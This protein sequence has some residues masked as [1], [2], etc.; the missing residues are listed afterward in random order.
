MKLEELPDNLK[1]DYDDDSLV[2]INDRTLNYNSKV[3]P[4]LIKDIKNKTLQVFS[5]TYMH[6]KGDKSPRIYLNGRGKESGKFKMKVQGFKPY[7]YV[8][9]DDGSYTTYLGRKCEKY[10][11]ETHPSRVKYFR[12]RKRKQGYPMP[13]EADILFVRRFL[14][15]MY[16]YFKSE[17]PI[18][19]RIAIIDIETNYP[20]N[21]D[22]IAWS[23][24]DMEGPIIYESKYE[25][26]DPYILT[27][28]L[29]EELLNY[30]VVTGWSVDFDIGCI[31]DTLGENYNLADDLAVVDL[32]KITRK[33]YAREIK[34]NWSLDNV[35]TQIC[36][37]GKIH[38]GA[39]AIKDLNREELFDYNTRD[40]IIPEIIDNYL[41]GIDTH[42][43][44]A[45]SLQS[46]LPE[47]LII[48]VVNDIS[49]LR[50]YHKA[51]KVLP[52]RAYIKEKSGKAK[53]KA[54]EPDARPGIYNGIIVTDL[55]HAYPWA[56]ISKNI[57]AETKDEHGENLTPSSPYTP[58]GVRFNN[59]QSV[60]IDTLKD[61]IKER[62]KVKKE[63]KKFKRNTSEYK[64]WKSIDFALKT[65]TAAFSHGIFGWTNSRMKDYEVADAI[66]ATVRE[67]IDKIKY[68][69][70]V[71]DRPWCY[72][73]TDSSYIN[74]NKCDKD[75]I[76]NYLNNIIKDHCKGYIAEPTLEFKD[77]YPLGYIHSPA[78]NVMIPEGVTIDNDKEWDVTGCNFMRSEV[79]EILANIEIK[80]L[81]MKLKNK[82]RDLMIRELKKMVKRLPQ[83][84][85]T[86]LGLVKPL[87]KEI[88]EYG[89]QLKDGTH[90]GVP[91]H[92]KALSKSGKEFNFT[93]NVGE[94]FMILPY[95]TGETTGVK[96]KKKKVDFVAFD[97]EKGLPKEYTIDYTAYLKSNLW[98]KIYQLF[99]TTPSKLAKEILDDEVMSGLFVGYI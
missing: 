89:K 52:S 20:V 81:K 28:H 9:D 35:G 93:V 49:L 50:A 24:N 80:L 72:A 73:H 27:K 77:Y 55:V 71:I 45:W 38:L 69:C 63:L 92:I 59:G 5:G 22:V 61:L 48:A 66:T 19:P 95:V 17:E 83:E 23:I 3:K 13:L 99:D 76:L 53:Y 62:A 88:Y 7:C 2:Y 84:D 91:Y 82:S 30:D 12:E 70:D 33:M 25:T 97:I 98:G 75:K 18:K 36:G 29:Y 11:F 86:K 96:V 37:L 15:D 65:Q 31:L 14:C 41:G 6:I 26:P 1:S 68:C 57:S 10:I 79:P 21:D 64:R 67:L 8:Y 47:M 58:N 54:A 39:K 74:G 51:G 78:R 94:K 90:G 34:G 56:V 42:L 46:L 40:V 85:S 87:K 43:I 32:L 4:E 60:F 16:D 44:L